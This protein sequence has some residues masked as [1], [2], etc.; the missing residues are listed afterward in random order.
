MLTRLTISNYAL[1]DELTV[2]FSPGLNIITGETGAGKS[3]IMG[4]LSL[5]LGA[6]ADNS[7]IRNS[8]KKCVVEGAFMT[9]GYD[10][11]P[12][13]QQNDL[14]HDDLVILRREISPAGKSRAFINDT[15][16]NLP[17]L[18]ELSLKLIDIHSQYQNLE[19]GTRQFQLRVVDV[20]AQNRDIRDRYVQL[21]E[22]YVSGTRRLKE[23]REKAAE[24]KLELGYAE[25]QFKQLETAR[26][27]EG[28]QTELEE[29]RDL[30]M[31]AEEIKGALTAVADLLDGD[32]FPVIPQ[33]KECTLRLEKIKSYY[34]EADLLL[35]RLLSLL[36]DLQDI[37]RETFLLAEKTE[38]NPQLLQKNSDRLDL[39]YSLQQK[40]QV[41]SVAEL[42]GLMESFGRK[43][44][45]CI[46][47]EEEA[48]LLE[49]K[50]KGCEAA[51]NAAAAALTES[52][53]KVFP[54]ISE[55]VT[56]LLRQVGIPHADFQVVGIP[57]ETLTANGADIIRF[58]FSANRNIFPEE[59]SKIASGGEISRVML[60]IK[61][62][63]SGSRMLPTIIFDE[64][65]S[66]ISGEI[67]L[68]M[69][70]ILRKLAG[71]MQVINITHLPQI[72]GM[73]DHH[74]LVYKTEDASGSFTTI[75]RL[76][77]TERRDELAKMVGGIHPS[78]AARKTAD[79][80]LKRR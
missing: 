80:M 42:I 26:L 12:F 4:A 70:A 52:R 79:E 34:K 14:D 63:L 17:L 43:A 16:V 58:L 55:K 50:L 69:G 51:L 3:I 27:R 74:Y 71:N 60:A 39:I 22:E 37:S 24:A 64:I 25:F 61:S 75:R 32:H 68:K 31:H 9:G 48:T 38:Y 21:F 56:S 29:E 49:K 23:L 13:F 73:G 65:D 6:R 15:P 33:L 41:T 30:L 45:A 28:E 46:Q 44:E 62:L 11:E 40:H 19:L 8:D 1:I 54:E 53:L 18:Q 76:A 72:A 66:G 36:I 7:G 57:A 59:I 5:I 67:A 47:Y 2:E 20:V 35:E 77:E 10:L 78:E